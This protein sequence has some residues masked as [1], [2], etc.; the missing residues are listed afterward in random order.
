VLRPL[1][2]WLARTPLSQALQEHFWI[3][4]TSQSIHILAVSIIVISAA[5][6]NFRLLGV[7]VQGR[8]VSQLSNALIPWM[9]RALAIL[10]MTGLIQTLAEPVRQFVTPVYWAKMIMIVVVM[11]MTAVYARTLRRQGRGWDV[12]TSR[13][14]AARIFA[15]VSMLLWIAIIACGRF[16]GYTWTFYA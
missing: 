6:I 1:A 10:L 7:G 2:E 8:T 3:V 9:W 14:A 13:P 15:V 11:G 5:M 4:P 16:I 12:G